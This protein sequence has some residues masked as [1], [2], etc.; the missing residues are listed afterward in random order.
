MLQLIVPIC[1]LKKIICSEYR[2]RL[3]WQ[4]VFLS[5]NALSTCFFFIYSNYLFLIFHSANQCILKNLTSNSQRN[6]DN[7]LIA[8]QATKQHKRGPGKLINFWNFDQKK[9]FLNFF[10]KLIVPILAAQWLNI[11]L[12]NARPKV[13]IQPRV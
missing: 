1:N 6:L 2:P 11:H 3:P 13:W 7:I 9:I 5:F 10:F 4:T 8:A 12:T